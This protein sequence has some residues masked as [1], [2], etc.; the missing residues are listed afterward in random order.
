MIIIK[1]E[2]GL[3][4]FFNFLLIIS[5]VSPHSFIDI[6]GGLNKWGLYSGGTDVAVCCLYL[7]M[8]CSDSWQV[9]HAIDG[10]PFQRYSRAPDFFLSQESWFCSCRAVG[11]GEVWKHYNKKKPPLII[12]STKL[13]SVLFSRRWGSSSF[14]R[15]GGAEVE[16]T[17]FGVIHGAALELSLLEDPLHSTLTPRHCWASLLA[18]SHR[19][20]S[21]FHPV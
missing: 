5:L 16:L 11:S 13:G 6:W 15:V 19:F 9:Y 21:P 12:L 8:V 20:S 4:L 18:P 14:L 3:I 1:I 2:A 10:R 17:D 7:A